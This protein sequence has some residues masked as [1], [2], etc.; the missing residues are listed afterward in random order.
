MPCN[1]L[2]DSPA[3]SRNNRYL[4][5]KSFCAHAG[6]KL[7]TS[8]WPMEIKKNPRSDFSLFCWRRHFVADEILKNDLF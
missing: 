7:D 6:F 2:S 5:F 3:R 8:A 1:A 4:I